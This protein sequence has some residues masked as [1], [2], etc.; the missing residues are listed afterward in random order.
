MMKLN[1]D[2]VLAS[3]GARGAA[4]L[5]KATPR[6]SG[7]AA[8]SWTYEIQ[9]TFGGVTIG[10][11]NTDIEGGFH[12]ALM[13]QL[14]HGTGT[15]G[16]IQGRDYINPAMRPVFDEIAETVWKAVTSA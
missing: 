12:V 8:N 9:K 15:G 14:G 4:A 3:A 11:K 6:D 2:P 7:I 1:I 13:I 5:A 10:W 16:Y